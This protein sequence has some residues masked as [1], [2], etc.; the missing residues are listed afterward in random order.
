MWLIGMI[1]AT[2]PV[3]PNKRRKAKEKRVKRP[4]E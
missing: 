4:K 2:T 1:E 3:D